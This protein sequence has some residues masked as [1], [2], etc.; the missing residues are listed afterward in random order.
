MEKK[1]RFTVSS[2]SDSLG[3]TILQAFAYSDSMQHD[4][5]NKDKV[6]LCNVDPLYMSAEKEGAVD[7][8]SRYTATTD[9]TGE[10]DKNTSLATCRTCRWMCRS[11]GIMIE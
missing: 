11:R 10:G 1:S 3:R 8:M 2:V 6:F 5:Q 7:N 4:L 9:V